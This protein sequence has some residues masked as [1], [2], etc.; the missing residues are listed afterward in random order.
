MAH[1]AAYHGCIGALRVLKAR[2][3]SINAENSA[4]ERPVWKAV[5]R[6]H[7]KCVAWFRRR[8][9]AIPRRT[10]AVEEDHT[11]RYA[12]RSIREK[13]APGPRPEIDPATFLEGF[14]IG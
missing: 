12:P 11:S 9:V 5:L 4:G 1:V 3:V 2:G 13:P 14:G 10:R 8:R 6:G 7:D